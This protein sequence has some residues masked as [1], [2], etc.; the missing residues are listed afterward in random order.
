MM[1]LIRELNT[2]CYG[3]KL[4]V[5][6]W[7]DCIEISQN[8]VSETCD[9][10]RLWT[11]VNSYLFS[12]TMKYLTTFRIT[13]LL[14][15]ENTVAVITVYSMSGLVLNCKNIAILFE[16][17]PWRKSLKALSC[18]GATCWTTVC[19][20]FPLWNVPEKESNVCTVSCSVLTHGSFSSSWGSEIPGERC[21]VCILCKAILYSENSRDAS[22]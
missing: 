17:S 20:M 15:R 16:I 3:L 21:F 1:Y 2:L 6:G 9:T 19:V 7:R 5:L 8:S 11:E 10:T 13:W 18:G 4:S 22:C 12:N 14:G